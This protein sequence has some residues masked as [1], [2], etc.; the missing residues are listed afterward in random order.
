MYVHICV[1]L[2]EVLRGGILESLVKNC[3]FWI[4]QGVGTLIEN[5]R[6]LYILGLLGLSVPP[7]LVP[8]LVLLPFLCLVL[9]E[10]NPNVVG[11]NHSRGYHPDFHCNCSHD[12][13]RRHPQS[14]QTPGVSG[15]H[16]LRDWQ[17]FPEA[18]NYSVLEHCSL[19]HNHLCNEQ[20]RHLYVAEASHN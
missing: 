7:P 9:P 14:Y 10:E 5:T 20:S 17:Y 3:Q 1:E 19:P 15:N 11:Y 13:L 8:L 16:F 12:V 18:E 4:G 6:T 2:I